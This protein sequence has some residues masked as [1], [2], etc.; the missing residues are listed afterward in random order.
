[1]KPSRNL[2][3]ILLHSEAGRQKST[4]QGNSLAA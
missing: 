4:L 1:V 2:V 3:G